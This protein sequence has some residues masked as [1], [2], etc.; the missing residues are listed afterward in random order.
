MTT[1]YQPPINTLGIMAP[2]L[3]PWF[4]GGAGMPVL[5]ALP[6]TGN[7]PTQ[8]HLPLTLN[9]T[10]WL[11][12]AT[13]NL[14]LYYIQNNAVPPALDS[15]R[16]VNGTHPFAAN[17]IYGNTTRLVAWFRLLPE[18]EQRLHQ[19]L[20]LL[21]PP[22]A[23]PLGAAAPVPGVPSRPQVRSFM[24]VFPA[25]AVIT[26]NFIIA[27]FN[28]A[29]DG[30]DVFEQM[31]CVGLVAD[32]TGTNVVGN[33]ALPMTHLRRPGGLSPDTL[34]ANMTAQ[35]D[36]WC[37]DRRGR[38]IDPGAVACWWSWLLNY[39]IGETAPGNGNFQL[40]APNIQAANLATP[41]ATIA[42][43]P[44]AGAPASV[45]HVAN[46]APGLAV[47]LVDPHEGVLGAPFLSV[48]GD[49]A[50]TNN[51]QRLTL[52]V[53]G[54]AINNPTAS[55][56]GGGA[57]GNIALGFTNPPTVS[58][59]APP[60]NA[61]T[62]PY[63]P[64][65]DNA[66]LCR[67]AVLPGGP[68]GGGV[69][70]WPGGA[71][72]TNLTRDFVRVAVMDE[73][74]FLVG[75]GRRR[76]DI[77]APNP[78]FPD[79][80]TLKPGQ[81]RRE[82]DQN[83]PSTRIT[84]APSAGPVLRANSGAVTTAMLGLANAA[85]NP[86]RFVLGV[87][88]TS[89][90]GPTAPAGLVTPAPQAASPFPATLTDAG[91]APPTALTPG[92]YR[93]LPLQGD[94]GQST[95]R[96]MVLVEVNLGGTCAGATLRVWPLGLDLASGNRF[97][98]TGGF[99]TV[100]GNNLAFAVMVLP[101]G[102]ANPVGQMRMDMQ[103]TIPQLGG[104]SFTRRYAA[105]PFT[106]PAA[107]TGAFVA[108]NA[109]APA[110][111]ICETGAGGAGAL[112]AGTVPAGAHVV[113][114][115][116]PRA[117]VDRTSIPA[118]SW[119]GT[120]VNYLTANPTA[121]VSLTEPAFNSTTDRADAVGRP[122]ARQRPS[123]PAPGSQPGDVAAGLNGPGGGVAGL[124]GNGLHLM[125]RTAAD[126]AAA[127]LPL[128]LMD[129]REVVAAS[130]AAGA[131]AAVIGSAPPVPWALEP[132]ANHFLGHPGVPASI[133][134]HGTGA[135]L[136]G[137]A[138]I[139]A[140]EYVRERTAGLGIA[141]FRG[142]ADPPLRS[143][144]FQSEVALVAEASMTLLPAAV[145]PAAPSPVA[146]VLRTSALGMEGLPLV[147]QTLRDQ[148]FYPTMTN[149]LESFYQ[150]AN[151]NIPV[152]GPLAGLPGVPPAGQ[153]GTWLSNQNPPANNALAATRALDR[154]IQSSVYGSR[155][156]LYS[157]MAAINRAED[158]IYIE[159]PELD[160][161][162]IRAADGDPALASA[163]NINLWQL[164]LNRMASRIG[165]RVVLCVSSQPA[166]GTPERLRQIR[167][168]AMLNAINAARAAVGGRFTVFAPGV[169]AGR[170]LRIASTSVVVDDAYAL[171]G[172]THLSR[173]GLSWDS[174]LAV[175]VFDENLTDG[176]PT[177]VLNFRN[178]LLADRL[179][180]PLTAVPIDPAELVRAI[181]D[182]DAR[183]SNRLS[184]QPIVPPTTAVTP[185]DQD[186]WLPDGSKS[187]AE[188]NNLPGW[189]ALFA[190]SVAQTD[191]EHA[192][193]EG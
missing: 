12:P 7:V 102:L 182:L 139:A 162:V 74:A 37:F 78:P 185:L 14:S 64:P 129:R 181:N 23:A 75:Y 148:G 54:T 101:D 63:N 133:E 47:H 124:I 22:T 188:L 90:G 184:A 2:V 103:V 142:I 1:T 111:V 28:N 141:A 21:P 13:G 171:T 122:M 115:S 59:P 140:G 55:L 94:G 71:L 156:A 30:D 158:L 117:L 138:A 137:G 183:G 143:V 151:A 147:C 167:D 192:M 15:L 179:G 65:A 85:N 27:M 174:S 29:L 108:A 76:S 53:N 41:G 20:G 52:S 163:E 18:V 114:L 164:L 131:Q 97:R 42:P 128:G 68:Y 134:V 166:P 4:T 32:P 161:L 96:Q 79:A 50:D 31:N 145:A 67:M 120:L 57:A 177:D 8:L 25:N 86:A 19:C 132:A 3:G 17:G 60:A 35:V 154:R 125:T 11:P 33:M 178:Q 190:T 51:V 144:I 56:A 44:T 127:S 43:V 10:A 48:A 153:V 39:G 6:V 92:Q 180:I 123:Q 112:P 98:L 69:T 170:A 113:Q 186:V 176:R 107:V 146:A 136:T 157:L 77:A 130:L 172:S 121:L 24:M 88:D 189:T 81:L 84:V 58:V 168:Q 173:R 5:P 34:V 72:H 104:G 91:N 89:W 26:T 38:P 66:P 106:R 80:G 40:L 159:T 61:T 193:T 87:T 36:F 116:Q 150:W 83:R 191:L 73:E 149:V 175:A 93:V 45:P 118:A 135:T 100:D 9:N 165:L 169:G 16:D 99:A 160:S 110:W 82:M 187:S 62:V 46:F 70:L 152:P 95:D 109:L 105:L 49:T 155:E 119:V 126:A